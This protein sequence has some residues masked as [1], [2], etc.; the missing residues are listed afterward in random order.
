MIAWLVDSSQPYVFRNQ[1]NENVLPKIRDVACNKPKYSQVEAQVSVITVKKDKLQ[2]LKE[3][4]FIRY[5]SKDGLIC[6]SSNMHSP[7]FICF[8]CHFLLISLSFTNSLLIKFVYFAPV[9][10]PQITSHFVVTE[11]RISEKGRVLFLFFLPPTNPW[12]T[13]QSVAVK[14]FCGVVSFCRSGFLHWTG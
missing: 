6:L 12:K 2:R 9:L 13:V 7:H 11:Q 3:A 10:S 5:S 14:L 1:T 4:T 8:L